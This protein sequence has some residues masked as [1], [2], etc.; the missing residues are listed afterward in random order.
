MDELYSSLQK[1]TKASSE[2]D[3]EGY[4]KQLEEELQAKIKVKRLEG[5]VLIGNEK[6]LTYNICV[7][8]DGVE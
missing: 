2:F 6:D 4:K 8:V 1:E 3:A 5:K 7:I